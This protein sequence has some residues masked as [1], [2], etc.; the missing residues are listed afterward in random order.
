MKTTNTK[1]IRIL[2]SVLLC[3]GPLAALACQELI[4]GDPCTTSQSQ[5]CSNGCVEL[6]IDPA[7]AL[8]CQDISESSD[9][10]GYD[11]CSPNPVYISDTFNYYEVYRTDEGYCTGCGSLIRSNKINTSLT[12]N[13]SYVSGK[14][15][16]DDGTG[17]CGD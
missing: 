14:E 8:N 15:C 12:C 4:T 17:F 10:C 2:I 16:P 9:D 1:S 7:T 5:D 13:R 3:A 6:V 11:N